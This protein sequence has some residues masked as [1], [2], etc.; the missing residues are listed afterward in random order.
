MDHQP[1]P[2]EVS[3]GGPADAPLRPLDAAP[4]ARRRPVGRAALAAA[5]GVGLVAAWPAA[6]AAA[7]AL[8]ALAL[9]AGVA[10]YRRPAVLGAL[11][12]LL[13]PAGRHADVVGV[14]VSPLDAVVVGGAIGYLIAVSTGRLRLRLR[15]AD[16]TFAVLL[17]CIA[18]STLGPVDDTSRMR[19][20]VVWAGLAVVFHAVTRHL[21]ERRDVG[22]L[23]GALAAAVLFEASFALYEYL[24]GW[25]ERFSLRSGAIVYPLPEGTLTHAN[26]LAQFLVL[27]GFVVLALSLAERVLLRRLGLVT[28]AAASVA[29]VVTFSRASWIAFAA[30]A[31]VFLLDRRTRVPVLVG[32]AIAT[33]AGTALA[34]TNAG[35]IGARFSSLFSADTGNLSSFRLEIAERAVRIAADHPLTGSG[36]F[37][38]I[39]VYAGRPDLAT[40]PHNLF[41][42]LAVFFGIPAALAFATLVV[43]AARAAWSAFRRGPDARRLT[44]VGLLA[45][46]AALLVNGLFEYPFWNPTLTALVVLGLAAAVSLGRA[47]ATPA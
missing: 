23:L 6:G 45:F 20:L 4:A 2:G 38:E 27:G 22:L 42:G 37:E 9:V 8:G 21:E 32:G 18:V 17:V 28:A 35:A 41:L 13:L 19:E 33:V 14:E 36:H 12:A 43:F 29:L 39:G 7:A 26:A 3:A 16:W 46:L 25:S 11:V 15:A 44:A 47:D 30:G 24:D 34:L 5:A 31:C 1:L 10:S 40:H